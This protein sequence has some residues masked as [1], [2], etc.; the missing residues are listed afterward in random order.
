MFISNQNFRQH[1][2][3]EKMIEKL[4]E[5]RSVIVE[6]KS[7]RFYTSSLLLIYEGNVC[8][9]PTL[10]GG[11]ETCASSEELNKLFDVRLID[12]AH[13]THANLSSF[14]SPSSSP[15]PNAATHQ[16]YDEGFVFGLDNLIKIFT[17]FKSGM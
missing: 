13:S 17:L 10:G 5:L 1:N 15:V 14:L 16:D 4:K 12:F 2:L 6:L 9:C 3:L 8:K 11:N 7:F